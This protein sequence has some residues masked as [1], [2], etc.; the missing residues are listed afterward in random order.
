MRVEPIDMR[1]EPLLELFDVVVADLA[2]ITKTV[3][4]QQRIEQVVQAVAFNVDSD[5]AEECA[6]AQWLRNNALFEG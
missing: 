1:I 2:E 5:A 6:A 4:L 3:C